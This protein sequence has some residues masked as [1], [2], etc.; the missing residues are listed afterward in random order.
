[1]FQSLWDSHF[2]APTDVIAGD[3]ENAISQF[4]IIFFE[5]EWFEV[6]DILEHIL[7]LPFTEVLSGTIA[8]ELN[9]VLE[10]EMAGYRVLD[11]MFT[12]ITSNEELEAIGKAIEDTQTK[13]LVFCHTDIIG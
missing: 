8:T 6:Y 7:S 12:P 11:N 13:K 4:R 2:G 10:Q 3:T 9:S 5:V 1:M